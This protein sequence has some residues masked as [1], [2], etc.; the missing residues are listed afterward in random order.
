MKPYLTIS[1]FAGLRNVNIN[2]LRYYEKLGLLAP[3]Y[4]DP[5]TKYRYY[6]PEQIVVLDMIIL[7]T[8]LGMPLKKLKTYMN[9][10]GIMDNK[11]LLDEYRRILSERIAELQRGL[12][13]IQFT[14]NNIEQNLTVD[15][16][17]G[18]YE[19]EIGERHLLTKPFRGDWNDISQKEKFSMELFLY[20]QKQ[21]MLPLFPAGILIQYKETPV[22]SFFFQILNPP[23][24]D[25]NVLILPK[26]TF[27]CKQVDLI[28]ETDVF[29]LAETCF[30]EQE[31]GTVIFSNMDLNKLYFH[32]KHTEIQ[33]LKK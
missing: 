19:R 11:S 12:D 26:N 6:L 31:K 15:N 17:K 22:V 28:P 10:D 13:A 14:L 7:A 3:A 29:Q 25:P 30:P 27:L 4:V 2:S 24:S 20:A 1:E 32:N 5:Q 18:L 8:R 21:N 23:A 9:A 16:E 33:L